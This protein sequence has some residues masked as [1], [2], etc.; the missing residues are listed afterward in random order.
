[1]KLRLLSAASCLLCVIVACSDDKGRGSNQGNT[2]SA[3][4]AN[5][6]AA[7]PPA[8]P[9]R[10]ARVVECVARFQSVAA[11]YSVIADSRTGEERR[12][13]MRS[14]EQRAAAM[15]QTAARAV[16]IGT[17]LGMTRAQIA[18]RIRQ[19][20][21]RIHQETETGDFSD[22]AVRMG[23]EADRCAAAMPALV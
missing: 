20:R 16:A 6:G 9:D 7:R 21:E 10:F 17:E 11:L 15:R 12:S 3:A 23:R 1:M 2:Q 18:D 22:F 5:S 4:P 8:R 19:A 14:A 13:L